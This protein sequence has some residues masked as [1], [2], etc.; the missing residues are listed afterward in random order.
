MG[1][2]WGSVT[3]FGTFSFLEGFF[4]SVVCWRYG[5]CLSLCLYR[6]LF[7]ME[8]NKILDAD[9]LDLLF[10]GRN[11]E[12]GAYELRKH[13]NSRLGRAIMMMTGM[14]VVVFCFGFV[15]KRGRVK[16]DLYVTDTVTLAQVSEV[17]PPP[18][19]VLP[20]PVIKA[21][22]V[23]TIRYVTTRIVADKDV[24][25]DVVPPENK[26]IDDAKIGTVTTDGV[27]DAGDVAPPLNT[28]NGNV[29]EAVKRVDDDDKPFIKVEQD[30]SFP[31]G[32]AAWQRYLGQNLRFPQEAIDAGLN[33]TVV[34]RFIVDK[35][36]K[37]SDV[38]VVSGPETGGVREE[39]VRV[40]RKSGKW[41]PAVQN[42]RYVKSYKQQPVTFHLDSE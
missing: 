21:P 34:V 40:I 26:D 6:K 25:K 35:D 14:V 30:A 13:Y 42:G 36:G 5:I 17:K 8:T 37:I 23:A 27:K 4:I 12:Y 31:G 9:V 10:D 41:V 19:V 29:V 20:K 3:L 1:L 32:M 2:I 15:K 16:A 24:P 33:G 7:I 28:G 22:P 18:E 11:K 39:V 38:E